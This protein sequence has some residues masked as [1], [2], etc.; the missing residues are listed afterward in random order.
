MG[1][2]RQQKK[3]MKQRKQKIKPTTSFYFIGSFIKRQASGI[4]SDKEWQRIVQGVTSGTKRDNEWYNDWKPVT[5]ND[6]KSS[7]QLI[8][9]FFE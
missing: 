8:F 6:N 4:S 2:H 5:A 3:T 9:F 1:K 7:F